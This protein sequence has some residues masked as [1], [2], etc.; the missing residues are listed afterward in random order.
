MKRTFNSL[1]AFDKLVYENPMYSRALFKITKKRISINDILNDEMP[2]SRKVWFICHCF[3]LTRQELQKL[4]IKLMFVMLPIYENKYP[5]DDR[6]RKRLFIASMYHNGKITYEETME[7]YADCAMA[8]DE[9]AGCKNSAYKCYLD[10]ETWERWGYVNE[11]CDRSLACFVANGAM[12]ADAGVLT[13][14]TVLY[15]IDKM[16]DE[17][18]TNG[19]ISEIKKFFGYEEL[20]LTD[21]IQTPNPDCDFDGAKYNSYENEENKIKQGLF[22]SRNKE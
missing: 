14:H 18:Y 15:L 2:F 20:N 22:F 21:Y 12:A 7:S 1:A 9:D 11:V 4:T 5:K 17:H 8:A 13:L 6:I 10:L 16:K 19:V 3:K